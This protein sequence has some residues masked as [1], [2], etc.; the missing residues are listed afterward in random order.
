MNELL[1]CITLLLMRVSL[2]VCMSKTT[3]YPS[4]SIFILIS[5]TTSHEKIPRN[6]GSHS[7]CPQI[8]RH[9]DGH[10]TVLQPY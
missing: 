7:I 4:N 1:F 3:N 8:Y 5:E 9:D 10:G 2:S 6:P